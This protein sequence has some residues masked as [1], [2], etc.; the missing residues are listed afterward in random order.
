MTSSDIDAISQN[1]SQMVDWGSE[2]AFAIEQDEIDALHFAAMRR[3]LHKMLP[4][5]PVLRRLAEDIGVD[6]IESPEDITAL[7]FPHTMYKSY[8]AT[9]VEQGRF[10]RMTKWF[11]GLTAIDLSGLDTSGCDSLESWLD[12]IEDNTIIRPLCSSGTS[13]KISFYPRTEHEVEAQSRAHIGAG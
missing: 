2:T 5:I 10:D 13:G 3:R 1:P 7:C 11:N 6:D 9:Y 4:K 8:S 12:L